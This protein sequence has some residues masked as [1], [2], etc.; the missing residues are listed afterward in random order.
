MELLC[1]SHDFLWPGHLGV[2][3]MVA[4]LSRF[5]Y[6][7]KMEQ[8]VEVYVK[9]CLVCQQNKV[10]RKKEMGPLQPLPIPES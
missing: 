3:P 10:E 6:R 4:L 1:K 7:S 5:Y 8:D 2:K 9:T